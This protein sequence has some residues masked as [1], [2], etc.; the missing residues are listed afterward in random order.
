MILKTTELKKIGK[1]H[2]AGKD[3]GQKK[4][5]TEWDGWMAS[6][7]QWTRTWANSGRWWGAEKAGVLQFKGLQRTEHDLMTEQQQRIKKLVSGKRWPLQWAFKH[8]DISMKEKVR[9]K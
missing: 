3:W 5:E 2:D 1:D 8:D 6:P 4:R 7:I 9:T